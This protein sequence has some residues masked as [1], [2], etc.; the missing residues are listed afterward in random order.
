VNYKKIRMNYKKIRKRLKQ[1]S[2]NYE[3]SLQRCGVGSEKNEIF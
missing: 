3:Q 1:K 2:L